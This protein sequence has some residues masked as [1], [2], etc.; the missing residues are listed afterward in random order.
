MA[1]TTYY[2]PNAPACVNIAAGGFCETCNTSQNRSCCTSTSSRNGL[3]N[4]RTCAAS[5]NSCQNVCNSCQAY[6]QI[7][8]QS[9][10]SH[11]DVPAFPNFCVAQNEIIIKN[12]TAAN[13]NKIIDNLREAW[14]VGR[15]RPH[16]SPPNAQKVGSDAPTTGTSTSH[17]A[18]SLVT[19]ARYNE[20]VALINGLG[21]GSINIVAVNDVIKAAHAQAQRNG[22]NS[23]TFNSSV[24]DICNVSGAQITTCPCSCNC[25]CD[26]SC[27]CGCSCPCLCDCSCGCSCNCGCYCGYNN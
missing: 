18:N 10:T 15:L 17:V 19:A 23:S 8:R 3:S 11:G 27:A 2:P 22:Y 13:W 5:C 1:Q 14:T 21:G 6:C 25:E 24:C 16:G 4:L 9:I 26:C 20:I 7:G 12:W